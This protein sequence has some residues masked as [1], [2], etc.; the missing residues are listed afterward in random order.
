MYIAY[1]KNINKGSG[2]VVY[3]NLVNEIKFVILHGNV[4]ISAIL[5]MHAKKKSV[6]S[7]ICM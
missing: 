1:R 2:C 7:K 4:R 3:Y 5:V 6:N